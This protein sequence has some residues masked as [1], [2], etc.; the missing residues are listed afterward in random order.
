MYSGEVL[1]SKEI[2]L[3]C[4]QANAT[5]TTVANATSSTAGAAAETTSSVSSG[6]RRRLSTPVGWLFARF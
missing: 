6:G 2:T 3:E 4:Q 5:S 1:D